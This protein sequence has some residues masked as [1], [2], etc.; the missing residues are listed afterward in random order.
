LL[1]APVSAIFVVVD[2]I[3]FLIK[4]Q[5]DKFLSQPVWAFVVVMIPMGMLALNQ[6]MSDNSCCTG[7]SLLSPRHGVSVYVLILLCGCIYFYCALRVRTAP[8]LL[9]VI[10]NCILLSGIAL[11]IVM[12]FQDEEGIAWVVVVPMGLLLIMMLIEN[13]Q[14]IV[15][16]MEE[17]NLGLV[18]DN[19]IVK[20]SWHLLRWPQVAKFPILLLLCC[21]ILVILSSMLFLFG[22]RPDSFIRAFTE[23][24]EHGLSQLHVD[25]N[26]VDCGGGHYLCTIA[27]KGHKE[28]VKPVRAGIRAGAPIKCNRQLL[29]ANAFEEWLEQR[30]A[31][32]H[33][34]VRRCYNHV[35]SYLHRHYG[36]FDHTW[37]SDTI[38]LLMKPLEWFFLLTLYVVDR[39]PEN[40]IAQQYMSRAD[41]ENIEV[42]SRYKNIPH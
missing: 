1:I 23:T 10:V 13:H 33:R 34:P 27:A 32:L 5:R 38:Y 4:G 14:R 30:A 29:I 36:V 20:M 7:W 25:C 42:A 21:P 37:V 6:S 35:G 18:S 39:Q 40:R 26:H 15:R 9:E 31:W 24:Y 41:R 19:W 2:F 3:Y 17:D 28:I 8:P 16:E 12:G 11:A 22:Q